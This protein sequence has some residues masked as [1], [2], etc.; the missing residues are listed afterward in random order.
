MRYL[1]AALALSGL[2]LLVALGAGCAGGPYDQN[3]IGDVNDLQLEATPIAPL[4]TPVETYN[5]YQPQRTPPTNSPAR[6]SA[7]DPVN[8]PG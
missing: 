8:K 4:E 6:R 3:A 1:K 5:P 7:T 2:S